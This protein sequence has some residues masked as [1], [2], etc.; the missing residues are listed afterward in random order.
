MDLVRKILLYAEK[1]C[2]YSGVSSVPIQFEDVDDPV[3]NFHVSLLHEAKFVL[4]Y[5]EYQPDNPNNAWSIKTKTTIHSLTWHGYEFLDKI[6]DDKQWQRIKHMLSRTG[7]FSFETVSRA[8]SSLIAD[9]LK[10]SVQ[11]CLTIVIAYL[12]GLL[13]KPFWK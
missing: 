5:T 4:S 2:D 6:R 7:D 11:S 3:V 9:Q 8:A 1:H 10:Q 12:A 13:V